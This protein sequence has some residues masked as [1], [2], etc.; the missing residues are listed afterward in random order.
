MGEKLKIELTPLLVLYNRVP[1][2]YKL[3]KK[4]I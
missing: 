1:K 2:Q 3:N 4:I